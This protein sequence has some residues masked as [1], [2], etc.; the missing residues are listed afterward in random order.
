MNN[1]VKSFHYSPVPPIIPTTEDNAPYTSMITES[2][3]RGVEMESEEPSSS[4]VDLDPDQ[5][6]GPHCEYVG[7][8]SEPEEYAEFD[9]SDDNNDSNPD[10]A[11]NINVHYLLSTIGGSGLLRQFELGPICA[12]LIWM[13]MAKFP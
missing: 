1:F 7:D 2:P 4:N 8:F 10:V 3:I 13:Q 6:S 12:P 9:E 11:A 5:S